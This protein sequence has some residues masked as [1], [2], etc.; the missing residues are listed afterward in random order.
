[1]GIY[2]TVTALETMWVGAPFSGMEPVASA[3]IDDAENEIDKRL[4][5]KYDV[6]GWTTHALTPPAVQTLCKWLALGYL[7]EAT[8]RGSKEAFARADRYI[9]KAEQNIQEILDGNA[10]LVDSSGAVIESS[11]DDMPI[12]CNT[13]DYSPTFN[14]DDPK[15]WGVDEDK[16]DDIADERD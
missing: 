1:M 5:A 8:A 14:E 15:N 13:T 6:S 12:Y 7:H 10:A 9:K 16:L 4:A 11:S 3:C 2:S